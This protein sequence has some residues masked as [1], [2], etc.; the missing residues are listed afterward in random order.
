MC[1]FGS[2][3]PQKMDSSPVSGKFLKHFILLANLSSAIG[4]CPLPPTGNKVPY[5]SY[6]CGR[7]KHYTL[8]VDG[9]LDA[10]AITLCSPDHCPF[11]VSK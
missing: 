8:V 5:S 2:L 7:Q 3:L 4:L 10:G 11:H 1:F 9:L 6:T